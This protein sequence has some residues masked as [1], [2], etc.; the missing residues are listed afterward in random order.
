MRPIRLL[1]PL[2]LAGIASA[3]ASAQVTPTASVQ[4][5]ELTLFRDRNFA[6]PAM[7]MKDSNSNITFS[8]R[9]ARIT[10]GPWLICERPFFG[11]RCDEVK[12][13]TGKL[14]LHRSFSGTVRSARPVAL[15][16]PAQPEAAPAPPKPPSAPKPPEKPPA[17][18]K[19]PE[20]PKS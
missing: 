12:A 20:P 16:V 15:P 18:E 1:I 17:P 4:S 8:P 11:G 19:P 13:D 10:G 3:Q 5:G 6:G 7:V 9:S 14:N 2:A